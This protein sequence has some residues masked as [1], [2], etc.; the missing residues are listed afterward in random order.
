MFE[1]SGFIWQGINGKIDSTKKMFKK[2]I[3]RTGGVMISITIDNFS[4]DVYK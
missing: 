2:S 3:N 1:K 4:S